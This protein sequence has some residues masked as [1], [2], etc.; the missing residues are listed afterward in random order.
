MVKRTLEANNYRYRIRDPRL[1]KDDSFKTLDIGE[2]GNHKLIRGRLKKN[3]KFKTQSVI[4]EK[5]Y[6][7]KLR[8][9]TNKII[10]KAQRE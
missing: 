10:R 8:P 6:D 4:V 7:K 5:E 2:E 1:F 9:E 3:N